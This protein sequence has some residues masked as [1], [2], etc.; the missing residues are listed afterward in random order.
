MTVWIVRS[1]STNRLVAVAAGETLESL[2]RAL[3][4]H[5]S[6]HDCEATPM[7]SLVLFS[8]PAG[9][10]VVPVGP[11]TPGTA[12]PGNLSIFGQGA[13]AC[14][15][16]QELLWGEEQRITW[17]PVDPEGNSPATR[18]AK[19]M[20]RPD[21]ERIIT[22]LMDQ[23]RATNSDLCDLLAALP[24]D[25]LTPIPRNAPFTEGT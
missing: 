13:I 7:D 2:G 3:T 9:G 5:W 17:T 8:D 16:G 4:G 10:A 1:I 23:V 14:L 12:L 15:F 25:H 18:L 20:A 21:G 6:A 11:H 22:T 19:V 24:D